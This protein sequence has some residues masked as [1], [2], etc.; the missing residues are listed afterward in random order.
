MTVSGSLN[1]EF[2]YIVSNSSINV[3]GV[4]KSQRSDCLVERMFVDTVK[5]AAGA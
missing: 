2:V 5:V 3:E 1:S 4:V